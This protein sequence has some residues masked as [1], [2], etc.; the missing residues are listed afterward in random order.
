[1]RG[2]LRTKGADLAD[3]A[4]R[5][6][7]EHDAAIRAFG[8]VLD[9]ARS[10]GRMLIEAKAALPHGD[11]LPWIEENCSFG[12]RTARTYM[13]VAREWPKLESNRQSVADLSLARAIEII[14][15]PAPKPKIVADITPPKS[16]AIT[17]TAREI[18]EN[19]TARPEPSSSMGRNFGTRRY[20]PSPE[21]KAADKL[22]AD[23]VERLADVIRRWRREHSEGTD[24]LVYEALE[25]LKN[26]AADLQP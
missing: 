8:S 17:I 5:I 20:E 24:E 4:R 26:G 16:P 14:A 15:P 10:A 7:A 18:V 2:A 19:P 9:N 25:D 3:L 22:R 6:N 23:L 1:M 12:E 21:E 11:W 13:R